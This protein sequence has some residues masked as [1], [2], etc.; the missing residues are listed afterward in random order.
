MVSKNRESIYLL[1]LMLILAENLRI[2]V[3]KLKESR[4]SR[5]SP[6]ADSQS[7]G[8]MKNGTTTNTTTNTNWSQTTTASPTVN[9]KPNDTK[10]RKLPSFDSIRQ[11]QRQSSYRLD[12][13]RE[14]DKSS[15]DRKSSS[16]SSSS[17]SSVAVPKYT[18][19]TNLYLF[20]FFF[21]F[22]NPIESNFMLTISFLFFSLDAD[23]P[24]N[25]STMMGFG[26]Q[27]HMLNPIHGKRKYRRKSTYR[28][29]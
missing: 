29:K 11:Q 28:I 13:T 4:Q 12:T 25:R 9:E 22:L 24:K 10:Q 27:S 19:K 3:S 8:S 2:Q 5:K 18:S 6:S 14:D 1:R 7:S 26:K 16:S 17:S 23:D 15:F 20:L 21:F